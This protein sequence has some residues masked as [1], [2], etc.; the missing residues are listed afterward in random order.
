MPKG[1]R[2]KRCLGIEGES[3][4]AKPMI[5][6][7]ITHP[8]TALVLRGRLRLLRE[9]GFRVLVA[10]SPGEPLDSIAATEG[11]ETHRIRIQ[12]GIAPLSDLLALISLSRMLLRFRP[13]VVEFGTPK[14]GLLGSIAALVCRVPRRIY[15]IRGLRLETTRGLKRLLL[16]TTERIAAAACHAVLCNSPSIRTQVE[17]LRLAQRSK[18][19]LLGSGSSC[20]VDTVRFKP[21]P[22]SVRVV[23]GIPAE[24]LVIGFVGRLTRDKGIPELVE[25]FRAFLTQQPGARLLLVGWYDDSDDALSKGVR[26]QINRHPA[27]VQTGYV[28]EPAPYYRAMDILVLPTLREGFP[29]VVLEAAASGVP[30]ITT[31]ATG[32]QDSV[33]PDETG[34]LVPAGNG[35]AL[36][37]AMLELAQ[38]PSRRRRFGIAAREW[39]VSRF[40]QKEVHARN[41][42]FYRALLENPKIIPNKD[43][44]DAVE[45]TE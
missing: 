20:G 43:L 36:Y 4:S 3:D 8:Q 45:A 31:S 42:K 21:G 26:E 38:D 13:D 7:G 32:A 10:S 24:A 41:I 12:R 35:E 17:H 34:L 18:L 16:T 11:V 22:T 14:A 28:V 19:Y 15:L 5:V 6:V 9:A 37:S 30:V 33:V 44:M 40:E 2:Q 39:A 29:N 27:I 25:A 23:L 1:N